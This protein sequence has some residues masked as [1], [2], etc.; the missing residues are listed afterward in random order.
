MT[1]QFDHKVIDDIASGRIETIDD[2]L[3]RYCEFEKVENNKTYFGEEHLNINI[4]MTVYIPTNQNKELTKFKFFITLIKQLAEQGLVYF[5]DRE[6]H[7]KRKFPVFKYD[8]DKEL[9]IDESFLTIIRKY[10][11]K[12]IIPSPALPDYIE[13]GYISEDQK[14]MLEEKRDRRKALKISTWIRITSIIILLV[15]VLATIYSIFFKPE[16]QRVEIINL[17]SSRDS[18]NVSQSDSSSKEKTDSSSQK[19][20]NPDRNS[21]PK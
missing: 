14:Y 11:D 10:F 15:G 5:L 4:G 6:L 8:D 3:Q 16:V 18:F 13:R 9:Q 7:K 12:Q 2:F 1:T 19:L 21:Y 17:K 20:E